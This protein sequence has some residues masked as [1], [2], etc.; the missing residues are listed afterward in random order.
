M[1]I[2][3]IKLNTLTE[4]IG[5]MEFEQLL[6]E[7]QGKFIQG[8]ISEAIQFLRREKKRA[9]LRVLEIEKEINP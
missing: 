3:E 7:H 1:I 8:K 5:Q 9:E 6:D 2:D 4:L